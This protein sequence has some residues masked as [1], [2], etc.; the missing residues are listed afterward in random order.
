MNPLAGLLRAATH[1]GKPHPLS[2]RDAYTYLY[3]ERTNGN[4]S[5]RRVPVASNGQ[6]ASNGNGR[7]RDAQGRFLPRT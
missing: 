1:N 7:P 6:V 4:H 5:V 3:G 2:E